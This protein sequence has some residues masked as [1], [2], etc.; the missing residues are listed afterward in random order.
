[1]AAVNRRVLPPADRFVNR[2][3]RGKLRLS[4]VLFPTL[5]LTTT[6]RV[7]GRPRETPLLYLQAAGGEYVVCGTSFGQS[8]H[9]AWTANLLANPEAMVETRAGRFLVKARLASD[10]EVMDLWP[11]LVAL[12]PAYD[13][14]VWRSLREPR[15]FVLARVE[16]PVS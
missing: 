11:H 16:S 6:G 3:T 5:M 14:Y 8:R 4:D 15:V 7:S 2:M 13:D 1:M 12:W 10:S 9:P